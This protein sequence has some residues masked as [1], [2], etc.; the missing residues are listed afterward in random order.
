[1]DDAKAYKIGAFITW[2]LIFLSSYVYCI[3]Q[4]GFLFGL[5]LGWLPSAIVATVLCWFWPLYIL[6][7]AVA[8]Y[9]A[10]IAR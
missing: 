5:G 8:A 4:Y 9:F 7:I 10:F 1:M 2:V 6:A 3:F